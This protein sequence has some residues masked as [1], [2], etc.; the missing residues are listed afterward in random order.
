MQVEILVE[1]LVARRHDLGITQSEAAEL[2]GVSQPAYQRYEAGS[3]SPSIQIARE[4][5][6][7]FNTSVDYLTGKSDQESAESITINT[8]NSPE[9]F[10]IINRCKDLNKEQLER[11]SEYIRRLS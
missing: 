5:A 6:N 2:I 7:A 4:I 8:S 9:L 11:L 1:R 3:R 10:Y